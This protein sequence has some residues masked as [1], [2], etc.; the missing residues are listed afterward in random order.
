MYSCVE[1]SP[2]VV[3]SYYGYNSECGSNP[4]IIHWRYFDTPYWCDNEY[5]DK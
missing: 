5:P 3:S 4:D 1:E 2:P